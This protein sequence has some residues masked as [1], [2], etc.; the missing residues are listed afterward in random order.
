MDYQASCPVKIYKRTKTT[1]TR[2]SCLFVYLFVAFVSAR[3]HGKRF[4]REMLPSFVF[5]VKY[6]IIFHHHEGA[7]GRA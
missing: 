4:S 1:S 3:C 5:L 7:E 2:V 6:V